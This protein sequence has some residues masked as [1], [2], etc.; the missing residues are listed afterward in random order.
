[1]AQGIDF[2]R[3][4]PKPTLSVQFQTG[5]IQTMS[6]VTAFA[7]STNSFEGA[8]P[9]SGLKVMRA[10]SIFRIFTSSFRGAIPKSGLRRMS[11]VTTFDV[12]QNRFEGALPYPSHQ[13][14]P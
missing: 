9:E 3:R 4:Q 1:M 14:A 8:L 13:N 11:A 6:A 10:V 2:Q 7:I 12:Y 5:G